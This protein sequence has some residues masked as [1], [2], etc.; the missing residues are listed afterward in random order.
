MPLSPML[1]WFRIGDLRT[2]DH[3]GLREAVKAASAGLSVGAVFV[4]DPEEIKHWPPSFLNFV[5]ASVSELRD[6]LKSVGADLIIRTGSAQEIVPKLAAQ[7]GA[8]R[9]LAKEELEWCSWHA[10]QTT[11]AALKQDGMELS[12]WACPLRPWNE[13]QALFPT[14][15]EDYKYKKVT[16]VVPEGPL[17]EASDF[18]AALEALATAAKS[19]EGSEPDIEELLPLALAAES[20]E[21]IAAQETERIYDAMMTPEQVAERLRMM[22]DDSF[23]YLRQGLPATA[24][25]LPELPPELPFRMPGGEKVARDF[26]SAYLNFYIATNNPD[27]QR[28]HTQILENKDLAFFRIFKFALICGCISPRRVWE[29]VKESEMTSYRVTDL[30]SRA[31]STVDMRDFQ[32]HLARKDLQRAVEGPSWQLIGAHNIC[33]K[34]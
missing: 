17:W 13:D 9:V 28:M 20:A 1:L 11:K 7:I 12:T 10:L 5:Y 4:F 24:V 23:I 2:D 21:E 3:Q 26:L 30:G 32:S 22:P 34:V 18:T 33:T 14:T 25:D 8:E 31:K 27:W 15:T 19:A 16:P 6:T 29:E